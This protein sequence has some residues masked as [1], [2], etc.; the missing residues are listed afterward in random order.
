MTCPRETFALSTTTTTTT[1]NNKHTHIKRRDENKRVTLFH[2]PSIAFNPITFKV[3]QNKMIHKRTSGRESQF[4]AIDSNGNNKIVPNQKIKS[5]KS[6]SV[7]YDTI[8]ALMLF[9]IITYEIRLVWYDGSQH[10]EFIPENNS[11]PI[12]SMKETD[13]MSDNSNNPVSNITIPGITKDESE[14]EGISTS[15]NTSHK[16]NNSPSNFSGRDDLATGISEIAEG[17][18]KTSDNTPSHKSN[19]SQTNLS[20]IPEFPKNNSKTHYTTHDIDW[21][22]EIFLPYERDPIVIES[23]KLLFFPLE[24]NAW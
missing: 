23:H 13:K 10:E 1:T 6:R 18:S 16:S 20:I 11:P 22:D 3:R 2:C 7:L 17:T 19:S 8:F 24:K 5:K 4:D 15:K 21:S 9:S 12:R 14:T